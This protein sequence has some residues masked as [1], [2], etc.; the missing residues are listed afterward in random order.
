[1]SHSAR[2]SGQVDFDDVS[3]NDAIRL[4]DISR[5]S[6]HHPHSE[7]KVGAASITKSVVQTYPAVLM[8]TESEDVKYL[9]VLI[10]LPARGKSFISRKLARYLTWIGFD[11]KAFNLSEF[12]RKQKTEIDSSYYDP[13]KPENVEKRRQ[14]A[15]N[16]LKQLCDYLVAGGHLAIFDAT[17]TSKSRQELVKSVVAEYSNSYPKLSFKIV[18]IESITNDEATIRATLQDMQESP[19]Y[20]GRDVDDILKEVESKVNHYQKHYSTMDDESQTYIKV[21]NGGK[22]IVVNRVEGYL[23]GRVVSFLMHLRT[24]KKTIFMSRH[25]ESMYNVEGKIGGD[26][27]LSERGMEYGASLAEFIQSQPETSSGLKIWCSTLKRTIQTASFI[28]GAKPLQWRAL[29][30]IEVGVCDGMTY[31]EIE[32]KFPDEFKA[33]KTDKLRYRYPRGESYLDVIQ[34]LEPVIYELERATCP[35]LVVGHRAVLRCLYAYFVD[36]P[37][38]DVA[39]LKIPLHTV[40]KLIPNAYGTDVKTLEF[41]IGSVDQVEDQKLT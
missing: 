21:I 13:D 41:G 9:F 8:E 1:M 34:R 7:A 15:T 40:I 23:L 32:Q 14:L 36:L 30:E 26:S 31:E 20:A 22:Q 4:N 19:D 35:V 2:A 12:R 28:K 3:H 33:R 10:G 25:G 27:N 38:E 6:L 24:I 17:N 18:W 11:V 5:A 39:H 29:S 37:A 16:V